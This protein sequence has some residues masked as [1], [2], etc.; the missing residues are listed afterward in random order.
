MD[1]ASAGHPV[2]GAT[3]ILFPVLRN[4]ASGTVIPALARAI[5]DPDG[6]YTLRLPRS[7]DR[8]L[9]SARSEGALNLHVM[10]FYPGGQANW[11]VPIPAG[12]HSAPA[13]RLALTKGG[14]TADQAYKSDASTTPAAPACSAV[15]SGT[16]ESG[17]PVNMGYSWSYDPNLTSANFTYST[18]DS[19]TLGVGVSASSSPAGL[20]LAGTSTQSAGGTYAFAPITAN[21]SV[22]YT[23]DGTY[24][25]QEFYCGVPKTGTYY[26]WYLNPDGVAGSEGVK[27][28]TA[29][30]G[31]Y[32]DSSSGLKSWTMSSSTQQTWAYG[33][34]AAALGF[35]VNLS[36]QDGYSTSATLEYDFDWQAGNY[37][38]VCGTHNYPY[39][40]GDDYV[41]IR[42]S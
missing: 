42:N 34:D 9:T 3:V 6:R 7:H 33:V 25:W 18:D 15:G 29:A 4:P 11:F 38:P 28:T 35:G 36:S 30:N 39:D 8:L 21:K 19:V 40:A 23:G 14:V 41:G 31:T 26:D 27:T 1:V 5:T 12:Q 22:N 10:V 20:S 2:A 24:T 13:T 16:E 32:C 17:I 37:P